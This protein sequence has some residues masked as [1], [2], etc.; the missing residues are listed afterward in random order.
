MS[1]SP[2]SDYALLSDCHTAALV[3]LDGSVDWLC[4]PDFDSRAVFGRLLGERAGHWSLRPDG[5]YTVSRRYAGST[6][7][8]ET[9]FHTESGTIVVTDAL[10]T[11]PNSGGHDLGR[12]A[13]HLLVRVLECVGGSARIG[14]EFAPRPEYGLIHPLLIPVDGGLVCHGGPDTFGLSCPVPLSVTDMA[15]ARIDLRA[16]ERC[17]LS[18]QRVPAGHLPRL[19]CETQILGRLSET[20]HAWSSWSMKHQSYKGPWEEHVHH[21]GRVLQALTFRPT[22]AIVAAPTTSLPEVIRGVRNWDYRYAWVR[23]ASFT[24]HALWVAACPDEAEAFFRWMAQAAANHPERC[25]DLQ[26]MFG[27]RGERDLTERTLEHLEGWRGSR[28]V[29]IGNG[30]WNQRQ[31]DVYGELLSAVRRLHGRIPPLDPATKRFLVAT[32][33][34]AADVWRR[35][36][37]GIWEI[38]GEP[39]HFLYSKLMCWVAVDRAIDLAD[40]LDATDRIEAWTAVRRQ[41][42]ASI[43]DEGWSEDAHAYTQSYGSDVLDA[44]SLMVPIVGFAPGTDPRV[45]ATVHAVRERLTDGNGRVFR[46]VG[47]DD[48]LPG[49]E[50]TF[51]LCTFWLAEALALSGEVSEARDVFER[52]VSSANDVGLLAE[53]VSPLNG[54]LLGNFP[55]AFSH[56]GLVNAAWAICEAETGAATGRA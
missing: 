46:Y 30:A 50:G 4:L 56:I 9:T 2:L 15:R 7:V 19:P 18:L 34:K 24:L 8:L 51:L 39:R 25:D 22:G 53:E 11:G 52:A 16:G 54:E 49:D 40:S 21:S 23:D 26:V 17:A 32:A 6:M 3:S 33:D 13:P 43:E 5:P 10:A 37:Q 27:I 41:I 1:D 44:S 42:R 20:E 12:D 28:P 38:R 36:D 31:I 14:M 45:R 35:P 48:G 29:R 47:A 55:Q